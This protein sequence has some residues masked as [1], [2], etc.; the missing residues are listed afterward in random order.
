MAKQP[1]GLRIAQAGPF[2]KDVGAD[3]DTCVVQSGF[4][5]VRK[6]V[7]I[8]KPAAPLPLPYLLREPNGS[9][10]QVKLPG[11]AAGNT[12]SARF[13]LNG[14]HT[15]ASGS[16]DA[17]SVEALTVGQTFILGPVLQAGESVTPTSVAVLNPGSFATVSAATTL[18]GKDVLN[19]IMLSAFAA[20][21]VDQ[22]ALDKLGVTDENPLVC[23]MIAINLG[24]Q[25]VEIKG[26][27]ENIVGGSSVAV[28]E[29]GC[30][31]QKSSAEL[32][33]PA[34]ADVAACIKGDS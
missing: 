33:F 4:D 16:K 25:D 19:V 22:A 8:V 24:P 13:V 28:S 29:L 11:F 3:G 31:E 27:T 9:P 21:T 12:M 7:T 6:P 23:R 2:A 17:K 32:I 1:L 18:N 14:Y 10:V 5:N 15:R 26:F 30:I 34:V 20:V